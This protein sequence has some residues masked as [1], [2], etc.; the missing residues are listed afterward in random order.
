MPKYEIYA[1]LG[2]GFGGANYEETLEF[3]NEDEAEDYA[4]ECACQQYEGYAGL[5]GLRSVDQIVEENE[6]D[7][8]EAEIIYSEERESWLDYYAKE[9]KE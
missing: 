1:G 7:K 5:H 9:V 4:W 2:G 8:E 6:V 3:E